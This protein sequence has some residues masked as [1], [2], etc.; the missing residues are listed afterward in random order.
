MYH[1]A[2]TGAAAPHHRPHVKVSPK[3]H[4]EC[5]LAL[6]LVQLKKAAGLR[7]EIEI[8][9]SKA[10]CDWCH[11]WLSKYGEQDDAAIPI[12]YRATH[13]KVAENWAMPEKTPPSIQAYMY[14][15]ISEDM[16]LALYRAQH[17]RQKSDSPTIGPA[18]PVFGILKDPN[19]PYT[20]RIPRRRR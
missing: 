3:Q 18:Q 13:G 4:A 19:A 15:M 5:T 12:V 16:R 14:K 2:R 10:A 20:G 6:H 7:G 17:Y 1:E 9:I 11:T 8:G